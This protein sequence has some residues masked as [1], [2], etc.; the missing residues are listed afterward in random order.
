MKSLGGVPIPSH[1]SDQR[2][3]WSFSVFRIERPSLVC[4]EKKEKRFIDEAR[5]PKDRRR[6]GNG[7]VVTSSICRSDWEAWN[8]IVPYSEY[9][10]PVGKGF[11]RSRCAM[12][13]PINVVITANSTAQSERI[14]M[15]ILR[16]RSYR[17]YTCE[18]VK[19]ERGVWIENSL[20]W[21]EELL[22][23]ESGESNEFTSGCF[24]WRETDFEPLELL[25]MYCCGELSLRERGVEC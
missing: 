24:R 7:V 17:A 13:R 15:R 4:D 22:H 20:P 12:V 8:K 21:A 18:L 1:P 10:K 6:L 3:A 2:N 23:Q 9:W 25:I 16:F 5:D 14:N 11:L 19:H